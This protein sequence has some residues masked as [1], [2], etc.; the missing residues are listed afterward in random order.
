M[1]QDIHP[2]H[3]EN[4]YTNREQIL[5]TDYILCYRDNS[6]LLRKING[7]YAL[8]QRKD[9]KTLFAKEDCH[10]L[11][12]LNASGCFLLLSPPVSEEDEFLIYEQIFNLR[13]IAQKEVAWAGC[14]GH[15]L[16]CWYEQNRYC[17]K[18]GSKTRHKADERA[19]ECPVC[20][21]VVFPKISPA[22]IVA[23][24]CGDEI[25]LAKGTHYRG[26]FFSLIAGYVDVGESLEETVIREVKEEVGI[27]I[28]NIKYYKSQPWPFSGSMMVGFFAEADTR[29][30]IIRDPSEI[31][32]AHWYK[33]GSLPPYSHKI[34]IAGEMIEYFDKNSS[35]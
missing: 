28:K 12:S 35:N 34:S 21:H 9:F 15:Q 11:F 6:V 5:E 14:L 4:K 26:N 7:E 3:F 23:I 32:E 2:H 8:P 13:N 22:V 27:D 17:G 16:F 31:M 10:F 1:I 33:R 25:L 30:P 18:C 29:Q 24:T 20:F 19:V